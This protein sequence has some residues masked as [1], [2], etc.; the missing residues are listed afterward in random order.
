MKN[1][2]LD[3][4]D[5]DWEDNSA[6]EAGNGEQWLITFQQVLR[7]ELPDHFISHAPQGPYFK[8]EH[9]TNGAYVT[10]H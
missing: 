2:H 6:M 5:I 9:Y 4:V 7:A 3:G 10:V 1:N 8:K